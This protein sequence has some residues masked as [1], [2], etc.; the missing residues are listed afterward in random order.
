MP[1]FTYSL[2]DFLPFTKIVS[3]DMNR[4]LHDIADFLN[5]TK[6]D[7]TNIQDAGVDRATKLT[8]GTANYVVINDGTGKM[9]EE[10][11][12][13]TTRGGLGFAPTLVGNA[14]KAVV[15][16]NAETGLALGSPEQETLTESLTGDVSTLT[17]GEAITLNDACC[18]ALG[19]DGSNNVIYRVFRCDSTKADRRVNYL[20]IAQNSATVVA[21]TYTWVDSA[22]LVTSNTITWSINGRPYSQAFTT[23]NDTTLAA[24]ASKIAGDPDIQA[25]AAVDAGSNDRQINITGKGGLFINITGAVVTG[26]AS[27]ATITITNTQAPSGQTVRMRAFGPA[28]GM[29]GLSVGSSYYLG[30]TAGAITATPTDSAP[31]FVG[32]ALSSTVLFA[33]NNFRVFQFSTPS[34]FVRTHGTSSSGFAGG[35]ADVEHYNFTSW[36]AG[37]SD[38][39]S[40]SISQWGE[41]FLGVYHVFVDGVDTSDAQQAGTRLYNKVS[42]SAG[43]NRGTTKLGGAYGNLSNKSYIMN[44][45]LSDAASNGQ[46]TIDSWDGVSWNS[47]V[48]TTPTACSGRS[49]WFYTGG[50]HAVGGINSGGA[51][52]DEHIIYN[53]TSTSTSTVLPLG[54]SNTSGGSQTSGGAGIVS[55]LSTTTNSYRWAGSWSSSITVPYTPSAD[56]TYGYGPTSGYNAGTLQ[57]LINGGHDGTSTKN[58]LGIFNDISWSAGTA[59]T[60]ARNGSAGAA[61]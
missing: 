57:S 6:I 29:S 30:P 14:G 26:G 44:G 15:V 53:G 11:N 60:N 61:F 22:A 35:V 17:A 24:I 59:S 31:V 50:V 48:S 13:A 18:L 12:L 45:T 51:K 16:N 38:S 58:N 25:A 10:S 27:Q 8:A 49:G 1:T 7:S 4:K 2:A 23:D 40:R 32:Q 34:L 46:N 21:G 36:S 41:C 42:W 39:V 19:R 33:C 20:G 52:I 3:A 56:G 28:I 37:T 55:G 54:T 43:A 5:I 47:G 9:S